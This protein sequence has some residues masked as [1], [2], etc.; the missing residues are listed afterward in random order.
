MPKQFVQISIL[1][2]LFSMNVLRIRDAVLSLVP[3]HE[4]ATRPGEGDAGESLAP[5]VVDKHQDG[6][7]SGGSKPSKVELT[8]EQRPVWRLTGSRPWREL[9]LVHTSRNLQP[10]LAPI[11]ILGLKQQV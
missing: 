4:L 8:E 5:R 3:Q 1:T 9:G 2:L 10:K 6:G 7:E 11:R